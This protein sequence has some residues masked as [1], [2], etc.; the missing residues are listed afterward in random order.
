MSFTG[1]PELTR[2]VRDIGGLEGMAGSGSGSCSSAD[3]MWIYVGLVSHENVEKADAAPNMA[4]G[5]GC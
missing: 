5:K 3:V 2:R 1:W 4:R